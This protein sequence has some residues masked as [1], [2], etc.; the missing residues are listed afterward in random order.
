[1]K[2]IRSEANPDNSLPIGVF[3]SGLGGLTVVNAIRQCLPRE[4]ILYL[5]DNARVPYGTRSG[6]TVE[7]YARNCSEFLLNQRLKMLVVACNTVSA[8]ALPA[9]RRMTAIPVLGV[10]EAGVRAVSISNAYRV[11]IIG[12][13]GTIL[14]DAYLQKI[15][16]V[17][18]DIEVYQEPTP[19]L[20]PL[21]EEGW[22]EG[23][24]T[25]AIIAQYLEPMVAD[26]IQV[27]LLGC[28]H[29]PLLLKPIRKVLHLLG[30]RAAV[31][32]SATCM[33]IDVENMIREKDLGAPDSATGG[34]SCF[35]TDLPVSFQEVASR[36]LGE[37][38]TDITQVDIS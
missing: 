30:N 31:I 2:E 13:A 29:Y 9:I 38:L 8:V 36:F 34:L 12:T 17:N 37:T 16:E 32:D 14:S 10:I 15:A 4:K 24:I 27:L 23:E 11:G 33:A 1:M 7:R 25:E 6:A 21:V 20:V 3:D 26:E 35:I 22:L 19:L 28:T 18:P 5:G